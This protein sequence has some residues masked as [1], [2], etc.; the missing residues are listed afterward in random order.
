[1]SPDLFEILQ[2]TTR[3]YRKG[4]VVKDKRRGDLR[5][6]TI[7]GFPA[8]D[9]AAAEEVLIDVHFV[10]GVNKQAAL[11]RQAELEAWLISYPEPERLSG[12]PSYIELGAV[13]GDQTAA[14]QLIALGALGAWEVLTPE[15]LGITGPMAVELAGQ[16]LV[17]MSG[18]PRPASSPPSTYT[19]DGS[20]ESTE[21]AAESSR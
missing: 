11:E 13:I 3:V 7:D 14:L 8:V 21:S 10:V 19:S 2:S 5:V 18:W 4:D 15:R 9:E 20:P 16:G 12:G 17:M 6:V 1:M